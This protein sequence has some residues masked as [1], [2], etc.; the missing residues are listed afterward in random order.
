MN[1]IKY[2]VF[3]FIFLSLVSSHLFQAKAELTEVEKE[4]I[5]KINENHTEIIGQY[6]FQERRND[7]GIFYD[8][9]WDKNNKQI[10][11]KR[12]RNNYP[13]IRFSL[14]DKKNFPQGVSVLRYN[15]IDLSKVSDKKIKELLEKNKEAKIT[16]DSNKVINLKPDIYDYNDIKLSSFNLDHINNIDTNKGLLEISFRADFTNKR[17][18]LNKEITDKEWEEFVYLRKSLRGKHLEFWHHISGCRQWFKVQRDTT[19]HEIFKTL[20][21][22]EEL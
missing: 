1:F 14:F 16:L 4:F 7:I 11:I 5:G 3:L 8:F 6:P 15:D 10:I 18:E 19:T 20:K 17:P 9:A 13:V 21:P 2:K 12:D 22:H